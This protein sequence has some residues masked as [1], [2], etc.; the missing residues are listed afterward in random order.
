MHGCK[1]RIYNIT[2][3]AMCVFFTISSQTL[4]P[5][6]THQSDSLYCFEVIGLKYYSHMSIYVFVNLFWLPYIVLMFLF[7]TV[8]TI[9]YTH[10]NS[11]SISFFPVIIIMYWFFHCTFI[12][13]NLWPCF[14]M[15]NLEKN[16]ILYMVDNWSHVLCAY[17]WI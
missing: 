4:H 5:H 13:G 17:F 11:Y 15:I 16:K 7:S 8:L 2:V 1:Y 3:S 12:Q 10:C 9:I 6:P 14:F